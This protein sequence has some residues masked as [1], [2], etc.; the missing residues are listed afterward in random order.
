[1]NNLA[2]MNHFPMTNLLHKFRIIIVNNLAICTRDGGTGEGRGAHA[3]L[4][5]F[6]DQ[7]TLSESPVEEWI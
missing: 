2:I 3:P 5:D 1:M 4:P 7:L 6:A